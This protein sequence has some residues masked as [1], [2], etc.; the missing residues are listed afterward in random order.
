MPDTAVK[1]TTSQSLA[2]RSNQQCYAAV[3]LNQ[4]RLNK[5]KREQAVESISLDICK[6]P[7]YRKHNAIDRLK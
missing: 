1:L 4:G 6:F 2:R 5:E 7:S 3:K